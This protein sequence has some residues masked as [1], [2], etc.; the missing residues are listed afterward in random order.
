MSQLVTTTT[1]RLVPTRGRNRPR[2]RAKN[3][4]NNVNNARALVPRSQ[5]L[6]NDF[7]ANLGQKLFK[8]RRAGRFAGNLLKSGVKLGMNRIFGKGQYNMNGSA[9]GMGSSVPYFANG[10]NSVRVQH[11][12]YLQDIN[13]SV[14]FTDTSYS[15]NPGL[16]SS[17]P[18]LSSLANQF[19]EYVI[20][21]M[22]F[23]YKS[24][25][26]NA[27][28]STNTALGTVIMATQYNATLPAFASK[29]EMENYQFTSSCK[30]SEDMVHPI[31]VAKGQ[32]PVGEL[33]VRSGDISSNQD[34]RLYDLGTF[35]LATVGSQ[36]A[37]V[38]GELWITYDIELIKPRMYGG[39]QGY[40]V[41]STHYKIPVTG[42]TTGSAYFG[43]SLPASSSYETGSNI[44]VTFA[45]TT[46]TLPANLTAGTYL[47][48]LFYVGASTVLTNAI[49]MTPSGNVSGVAIFRGDSSVNQQPAAGDTSIMQFILKCFKLT[50]NSPPCVFTLSSGTLPGTLSSCDL[51]ITQLNALIST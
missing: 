10:N 23:I 32:N 12:E 17:F 5:P 37:A 48:G 30:P 43:S 38:I 34:I 29:M 22:A 13:S 9:I 39:M 49:A 3:N 21:G 24:T 7:S 50:S 18:W 46:L 26:A 36:A 51:I 42:I 47:I 14:S 27:L 1:K 41:L 44:A 20:H 28:N 2:R 35:Q 6:I 19:E 11:R 33:Y 8:S 25:S 16:Y 15:I 31:E 4:N 45:N 40:G